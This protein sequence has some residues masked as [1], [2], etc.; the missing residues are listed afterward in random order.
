MPKPTWFAHGEQLC[1]GTVLG[2]DVVA[3]YKSSDEATKTALARNALDIMVRRGWGVERHVALGG[4]WVR[5]NSHE[6]MIPSSLRQ[7]DPF[8]A[9]VSA[10]EWMNEREK[11]NVT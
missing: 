2:C 5:T 4:W 3:E 1:Y 10:D 8:T 9:L 7:S 6:A 11:P